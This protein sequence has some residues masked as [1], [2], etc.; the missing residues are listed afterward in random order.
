MC[1]G[2][3]CIVSS[4]EDEDDIFSDELVERGSDSDSGDNEQVCVHVQ[5]FAVLKCM[6][7]NPLSDYFDQVPLV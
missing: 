6:Y 7:F 5:F 2:D 3:H 4:E 1:G